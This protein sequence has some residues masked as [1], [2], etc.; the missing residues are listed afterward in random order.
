[1]QASLRQPRG[2][3]VT[4]AVLRLLRQHAVRRRACTHRLDFNHTLRSQHCR[5][6]KAC[7]WEATSPDFC[8]HSSCSVLPLIRKNPAIDHDGH[9]QGLHS[10]LSRIWSWAQAVRA[11]GAHA[12]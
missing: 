11:A 4:V 2:G 9:S 5:V 10:N 7:N 8:L 3:L 1:M 12:C 6:G